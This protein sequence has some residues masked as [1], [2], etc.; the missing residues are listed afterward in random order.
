MRVAVRIEDLQDP[1]SPAVVQALLVECGMCHVPP[2]EFCHA[3]GKGK[4][5]ASLVHMARATAHYPE[6]KGEK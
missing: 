6:A 2:R 3:I 1:D 4:K 5:M